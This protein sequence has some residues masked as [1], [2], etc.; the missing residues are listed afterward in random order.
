MIPSKSS[1]F[2]TEVEIY[3]SPKPRAKSQVREEDVI[4][5]LAQDYKS[6]MEATTHQIQILA[7]NP[8]KEAILNSLTA[9][10]RRKRDLL[11]Q[12]TDTLSQLQ[13][14]HQ[15]LLADSPSQA[16]EARLDDA[17]EIE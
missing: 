17:L 16:V 2:L 9:K 13:A 12:L 6:Y 3:S 14:T 1:G 11:K 4:R 10:I 7:R 5:E 15:Q 8:P